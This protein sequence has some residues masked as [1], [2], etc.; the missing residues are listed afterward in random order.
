MRQNSFLKAAALIAGAM[1][2]TGSVQSA[3]TGNV[4]KGI[5]KTHVP[6]K[7]VQDLSRFVGSGNRNPYK[8]HWGVK[9]QRQYRKWMRQCPHM[10]KTKKCRVKSK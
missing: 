4:D 3:S 7:P 2:A 5:I 8:H 1:L 10:R 9:N 6:N